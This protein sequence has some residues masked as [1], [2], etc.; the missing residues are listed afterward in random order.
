MP[1]S[2]VLVVPNILF[3]LRSSRDHVFILT[4]PMSTINVPV[5][6]VRQQKS[7]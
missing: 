6:V 4:L 7:I 5:E 2:L 3:F 1:S